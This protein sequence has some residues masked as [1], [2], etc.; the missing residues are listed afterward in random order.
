[1]CVCYSYTGSTWV[2]CLCR[3]SF[4]ILE[5]TRPSLQMQHLWEPWAIKG[6]WSLPRAHSSAPRSSFFFQIFQMQ[7]SHSPPCNVHPLGRFDRNQ[8]ADCS[9]LRVFKSSGEDGLGDKVGRHKILAS[10]V[11]PGF[12]TCFT[13]SIHNSQG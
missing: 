9:Y 13:S 7:K 11:S 2:L 8:A 12:L 1:M 6:A 5:A 10:V 3:S 4:G